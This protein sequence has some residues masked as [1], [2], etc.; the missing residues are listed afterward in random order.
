MGC[1]CSCL[2]GRAESSE[3]ET[4]LKSNPTGSDNSSPV[5]KSLSISRSMSAPSIEVK[6]RTT[7]CSPYTYIFL[8]FFGLLVSNAKASITRMGVSDHM[9]LFAPPPPFI[10]LPT[11]RCLLDTSVQR[12]PRRHYWKNNRWRRWCKEQRAIPHAVLFTIS[13]I[14]LIAN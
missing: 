12:G 8:I 10:A 1:L 7:V 3:S 4:E 2:K 11:H 14:I 6:D 13:S 5:H 9:S